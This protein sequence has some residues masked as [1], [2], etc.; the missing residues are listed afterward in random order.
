MAYKAL[1][2]TK[3]AT[4]KDVAKRLRIAAVRVNELERLMDDLKDH[5]TEQRC[6]GDQATRQ[7]DVELSNGR[8][9]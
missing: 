3:F 7:T 1:I 5:S 9:L 4:A 6:Q 2:T 8:T